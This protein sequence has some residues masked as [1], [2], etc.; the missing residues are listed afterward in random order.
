[1]NGKTYRHD[2]PPLPNHPAPR[3]DIDHRAIQTPAGLLHTPNHDKHARPCRNLLKR[4]TGTIA[5][6]PRTTLSLTLLLQNH[7]PIIV[8]QLAPDPLLPA[9]SA[10]VA[11]NVAEIDRGLKVRKVL[12]TARGGAP[13]DDASETGAAWVAA[14]V[15][16]GEEQEVGAGGLGAGGEGGYVRECEGGG[17]GCGGGGGG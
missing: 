1:M 13:A 7:Q 6:L 10:S 4:L 17:A 2:L 16:L 8:R 12:V 15:G 5:P 9:T 11:D 3:T 14:D